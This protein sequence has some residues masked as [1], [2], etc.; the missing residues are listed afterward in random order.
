MNS[1][2]IQSLT[3][4]LGARDTEAHELIPRREPR[5]AGKAQEN[6]RARQRKSNR[7]GGHGKKSQKRHITATTTMANHQFAEA[8]ANGTKMKHNRNAEYA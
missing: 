5:K 1:F 2:T 4:R 6:V 3:P 7:M 8:Q